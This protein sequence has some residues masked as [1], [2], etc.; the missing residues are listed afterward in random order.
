MYVLMEK[1]RNIIPKLSLLPLLIWSTEQEN[2]KDH[3]LTIVN[4]Y[5]LCLAHFLEAMCLS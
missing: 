1:I 2:Y 3:F 5:Q 4:M